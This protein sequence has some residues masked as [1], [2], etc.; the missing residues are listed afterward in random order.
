MKLTEHVSCKAAIALFRGIANRKGDGRSCRN[1]K[2]TVGL[3]RGANDG[4]D[5]VDEESASRL[6]K[7]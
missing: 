4:L 3:P 2:R 5:E 1:F 7:P 6:G